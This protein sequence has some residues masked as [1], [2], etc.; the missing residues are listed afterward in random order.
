MEH[1]GLPGLRDE[2]LLESV[3][4]RPRVLWHFQ[5]VTDLAV[6]AAAV[7]YGLAR[8]HPF[9]DGNKRIAFVAMAV[10]L[11]L[12]DRQV[13]VEDSEVVDAMRGVAAGEWTES[14]LTEW[15]RRHMRSTGE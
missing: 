10:F 4:E 2:G 7:G 15:V 9:A 12:N 5:H 3:L 1:G 13:E 8:R 6:L 14:K 11:D